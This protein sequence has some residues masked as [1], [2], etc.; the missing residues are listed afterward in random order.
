M[1]EL[2]IKTNNQFRPLISGLDLTEKEKNDYDHLNFEEEGYSFFR[3]KGYCYY[4][5]DFLRL[6]FSSPF[7]DKWDA[8]L[9]D[10]HFSG[11]LICLSGDGEAVCCATYFS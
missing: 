1:S 5:G 11:I 6:G 10:S 4:L 9:S 3:Y 2:T 7:P 8:Y